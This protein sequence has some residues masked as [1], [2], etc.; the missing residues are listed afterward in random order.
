MFKIIKKVAHIADLG[1]PMIY[2]HIKFHMIFVVLAM[3][4]RGYY[5]K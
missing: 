4:T 5:V 1:I 2:L 3:V